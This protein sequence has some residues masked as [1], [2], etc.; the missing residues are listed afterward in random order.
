MSHFK[1][2]LFLHGLLI[3]VCVYPRLRFDCVGSGS[4]CGQYPPPPLMR[5]AHWH[6]AYPPDTLISV[7]G[8]TISVQNMVKICSLWSK[9]VK[10]CPSCWCFFAHCRRACCG[11][12]NW[13]YFLTGRGGLGATAGGC[14]PLCCAVAG[15]GEAVRGFRG[16]ACVLQMVS[17]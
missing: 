15:V 7:Q 16:V 6:R 12:Q 2:L 13:G 11:F 3:R 4:R 1:P 10:K 8:L 5:R 9:V 14:P 17:Q